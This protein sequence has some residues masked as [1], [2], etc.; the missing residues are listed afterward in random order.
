MGDNDSNQDM[1]KSSPAHA[2]N[3]D[4]I[5]RK[6]EII[7]PK[8]STISKSDSPEVSNEA[9]R[10]AASRPLLVDER[11]F[12]DYKIQSSTAFFVVG[13][14]LYI[15]VRPPVGPKVRDLQ[16]TAESDASESWKLPYEFGVSMR[17]LV[18][19]HSKKRDANSHAI[20]YT[21]GQKPQNLDGE[22]LT[23]EPIEVV[24]SNSSRNLSRAS[25]IDFGRVYTVYWN[26]AVCG[27][28]QVSKTH[29]PVLLDHFQSTFHSDELPT[30]GDSGDDASSMTERSDLS[31]F[32]FNN[33]HS[34]ILEDTA[35]TSQDFLLGQAISLTPAPETLSR[36]VS[37]EW[38]P[39]LIEYSSGQHPSMA[40][41]TQTDES[42]EASRA[43]PISCT[44]QNRSSPRADTLDSVRS[45]PFARFWGY[46]PLFAS[47]QPSNTTHATFSCSHERELNAGVKS[48]STNADSIPLKSADGDWLCD[49]G[50][51]SI[52]LLQVPGNV[53]TASTANLDSSSTIANGEISAA[54]V[55]N[56]IRDL[57][58]NS[59]EQPMEPSVNKRLSPRVA[60]VAKNGKRA[61]SLRRQNFE[62]QF[63]H[64]VSAHRS[65]GSSPSTQYS[66]NDST[67][68]SE[69]PPVIVSTQNPQNSVS[70]HS[71][72][73]TS[74]RSDKEDGCSETYSEDIDWTTEP[75]LF[76]VNWVSETSKPPTF[77]DHQKSLLKDPDNAG[78]LEKILGF[79]NLSPDNARTL[80]NYL[81]MNNT[82]GY[83]HSKEPREPDQL[84]KE[85]FKSEET[86]VISQTAL[87]PLLK[88]P[89]EVPLRC[90]KQDSIPEK[91]IIGSDQDHF[92][93]ATN[94]LP[95][96][97]INIASCTNLLFALMFSRHQSGVHVMKL[98]FRQKKYQI[99]IDTTNHQSYLPSITFPWSW[100]RIMR[101]P[102]LKI[103]HDQWTIYWVCECGEAVKD[104][105]RATDYNKIVELDNYLNSPDETEADV[106]KL[107]GSS[108]L[109]SQDELSRTASISDSSKGIRNSDASDS[110]NQ[111][112]PIGVTANMNDLNS[113][114]ILTNRFYL[115][116]CIITTRFCRTL[117]EVDLSTSPNST[118]FE[119]ISRAYYELRADKSSRTLRILS[120]PVTK[121]LSWWYSSQDWA[122][123]FLQLDRIEFVKV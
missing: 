32:S 29:I 120:W 96:S 69:G 8:E 68:G 116:L 53:N 83:H 39:T 115:E 62:Q 72:A 78:F 111:Q 28:G 37:A 91:I 101:R 9:P 3:S 70:S 90:T 6:P 46:N 121:L 52:S 108:S 33:H 4:Y 44:L 74:V 82:D 22:S 61:Q 10:L 97:A 79:F 64:L 42:I 80:I 81:E 24:Q 19:V 117:A 2:G 40:Q 71:L 107:A 31:H 58:A 103:S 102:P 77:T 43:Y 88:T 56:L 109:A 98:T 59:V 65:S 13:R 76:V 118:A 27:L 5:E 11:L 66:G 21:Q 89:L 94:S 17:R 51:G 105:F 50:Q 30:Q 123:R 63:H 106:E 18:I 92:A 38:V 16:A 15:L 48:E 57:I 12:P 36:A 45:D 85:L 7:D 67:Y 55:V 35:L 41:A 119:K 23:K 75:G 100:S 14:V 95:P 114:P 112:V 84:S 113:S 26:E 54:T 104:D 99:H 1:S 73:Q 34:R 60:I 122:L 110:I 49:I 20:I 87:I 25:R 86:S 47:P 93:A